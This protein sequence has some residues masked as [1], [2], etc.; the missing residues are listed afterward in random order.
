MANNKNVLDATKN[1]NKE[2]ERK[3][4]GIASDQGD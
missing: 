4:D 3:D 2:K 1:E